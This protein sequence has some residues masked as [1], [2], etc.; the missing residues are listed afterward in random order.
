MFGFTRI[1]DRADHAISQF[2]RKHGALDTW[3]RIGHSNQWRASND[4]VVLVCFY[5]GPGG[6]TTTYW[7]PDE[8]AEEAQRLALPLGDVS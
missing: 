2:L 8:L 3:T 7:V 6:K 1:G 4:K 5:S